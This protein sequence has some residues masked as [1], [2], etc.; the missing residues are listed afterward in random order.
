MRLQTLLPSLLLLVQATAQTEVRQTTFAFSDGS[1]P[2]F[3][4]VFDGADAGDL[5]GWYKGQFKDLSED[6]E[7]KKEIRST[8][9]RVPEVSPDTIT[10]WCKAEKPKNS[11]SVSLHLAFRV[12][13]AWVAPSSDKPL[14]E[15]AKNFCYTRA[16][17][18]KKMLLQA[19]QTEQEKILAR[20][21][22]ELATLEKDHGRFGE[23]IEKTRDKGTKAAQDKVQAEADLKNN[24]GAVQAKQNEVASAPSEA[25]TKGLQ[26]LLKEQAKLKDRIGRLG[27]QVVDAE[28]RVKELEQ[29]I[30][31]NLTDQE[32]KRKAIEAQQQKV[33]DAQAALKN[34]N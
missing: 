1:H 3:V 27:D 13:G 4:V 6:V 2:T 28:E 18:Y 11:T 34:V 31:R 7:D 9:A 20:M 22:G 19:E 15:G 17:A 25:N 33:A 23:S 29:S 10:V 32:T 24:E 30:T 14:I 8:G 5:E 26:D 16:L 12:N 21:Q